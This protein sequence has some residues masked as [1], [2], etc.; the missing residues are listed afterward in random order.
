MAGDIAPKSSGQKDRHMPEK[1]V[2]GTAKVLVLF[3]EE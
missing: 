3:A 2:K 1:K